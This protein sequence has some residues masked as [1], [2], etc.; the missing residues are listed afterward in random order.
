MLQ[1][2][3]LMNKFLH[4]GTWIA[5]I[6]SSSAAMALEFDEVQRPIDHNCA[7]AQPEF[8]TILE[9][10]Q[11]EGSF[12]MGGALIAIGRIDLTGIQRSLDSFDTGTLETPLG[13]WFEDTTEQELV[14][15]QPTRSANSNRASRVNRVS[16]RN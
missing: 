14:F 6:L 10:K 5:M 16:F 3:V 12:K 9:R 8:Q 11:Q 1:R 15:T 13:G 2:G 7:V 4:T